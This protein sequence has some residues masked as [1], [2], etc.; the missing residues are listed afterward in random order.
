MRTPLGTLFTPV[1]VALV[2]LLGPSLAQALPIALSDMSSDATPAGDLDAVADFSI[3]GGDEL[4]IVLSNATTAPNEFNM[5]E[6]YFNGS[7]EVTGLTLTSANHSANGDVFA[8]WIPVLTSQ[9]ADGFGVFDF[10]LMD[11]VGEENPAQIQ[12]GESITFTLDILG[13]CALALDCDAFD[14]FLSVGN[15][16]GK[17]IAAKFVNGPDDPESPGDEDSAFG[18]SAPIPEPGTLGLT[19]LGLGVLAL[20]R[21]YRRSAP[22]IAG[23]LR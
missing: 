8:D 12:P 5:N 18:A 7:S 1:A 13:A 15:A 19:A 17:A 20:V 6:L 4:V 10:L 2:V 9:M 14:D 3:V 23:S 21:R 11:G 16:E 22:P